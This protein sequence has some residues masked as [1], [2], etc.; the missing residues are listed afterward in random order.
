MNIIA[1][2]AFARKGSYEL[3][4]KVFSVIA[5]PE[6]ETHAHIFGIPHLTRNINVI[7]RY[8]TNLFPEANFKIMTNND[9]AEVTITQGD[10]EISSCVRAK[11]S[12]GLDL[13][14]LAFCI[15]LVKFH[16][17]VK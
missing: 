6:M 11:Y 3:D 5:T 4:K 1:D 2:L 12:N 10:F 15:I 14:T 13:L 17:G 7:R 8:L 9:V 16:M